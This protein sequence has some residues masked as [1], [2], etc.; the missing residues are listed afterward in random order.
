MDE[1]VAGVWKDRSEGRQ[2]SGGIRSFSNVLEVSCDVTR[3]RR[4]RGGPELLD[5]L[6]SSQGHDAIEGY[7]GYLTRL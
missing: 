3:S 2:R 6:V 7:R 4:N 5:T 1:G